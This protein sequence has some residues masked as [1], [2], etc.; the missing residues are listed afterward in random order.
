[1]AETETSE[2]AIEDERTHAWV[3][4]QRIANADAEPGNWMAHGRTWSEQRYSPLDQINAANVEGLSLAWYADLDTNRGQEATPIVV[5]GVLFSTSAWSKVQAVDAKTG[6]MLWQYDPEVPG[7]WDVRACCGVQNRGP[8]IWKGNVI[9]AT[10]DGR[11]LSL[12]AQTGELNWEINT[13]DQAQSYTITGAPRVFG[14]KIVIGNGGAEYGVRGYV[15]AYDTGSG[16]MLWRFY[17]VPGNPADGF[18]DETQEMAA[19]TWTG[20]WWVGGGGGTAWDSFAYDPELNLVY[21]GTGNGAPWPRTIRSPDGGDNLFLASIVAVDADTGEYAWHYQT[22]PG[23]TWDYTAVQHMVLAELEFDGRERSVIMQA[24]KNGFFYVIDRATGEL[25]SAENILP[26]NG[27]THVDIDTGRP[28]ETPD[29]RYDET[30]AAKK[31]VPGPGGAHNWQ[32]MTYNPDTG[33]VYI[34]AKQQPIVYKLNENYEPVPIGFNLGINTW[35]PPEEFIDLGP[36]FG[37]EYQGHLLAWDPVKQEEVWRVSHSNFE[38]GGLLSTAGNLLFQGNADEEIVAFNAETGERLWSAPTQTGILAPPITYSVDGEQYVAVV[39]GWGAVSANVMGAVMNTEG[40][41]RNVSRILAFKLGGDA[42]LP[43]LSAL[44]EQAPATADFGT[45]GQIDTGS[46]LYAR[47][48]SI[49]HGASVIGG[50]VLQDLRYSAMTT[51]SEAF[52]SVVLDGAFVEKG[53]AGFSQVLDAED[54]EA[55]RAYIVN[56]GHQ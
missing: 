21:I 7:I 46:R 49:C 37:E 43:P 32:P 30:L 3:D 26:V 55:I 23:D 36:E 1:P 15:S 25:I 47:F 8:A 10:L 28:V 52:D 53:M 34:P 33:Y 16:E 50:G 38:N 9:S 12:N 48:C 42:E 6:R 45:E 24:P 44:P 20:E 39:A 27:A 14:D 29:A 2:A 31:I 54:T 13:T 18:E 17:T 22:V 56:A 4:D 19:A 11:L 35:D 51:N 40:T 5:D 41:R